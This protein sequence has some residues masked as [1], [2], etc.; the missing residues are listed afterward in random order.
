MRLNDYH[1]PL[2]PTAIDFRFFLFPLPLLPLS[3]RLPNHASLCALTA[4][5]P[6]ML[7]ARIPTTSFAQACPL[8]L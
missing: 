7:F 8:L 5:P 2:Y 3:N 6:L 4:A 1:D